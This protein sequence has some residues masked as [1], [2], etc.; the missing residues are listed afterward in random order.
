MLSGCFYPPQQKPLAAKSI[1]VTLDRPYDLA[2]DAVQAVVA[3]NGFRVI[4]ANPNDGTIEAQAIGKGFTLEDADC[5]KLRG[6][7]AKIDAEP[8]F[9]AS[10]VYD[11]RVEAKEPQL[12]T[13][14]I[15]AT[16][17]APLHVPLHPVTDIE[18]VSRGRQEARLLGEI[19][20][21]APK[22]RR[23]IEHAAPDILKNPS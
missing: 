4:T 23:A 3:N 7:G 2:W 5:G 12:S 9:D 11:L 13:V 10:A 8:D 21:E 6:A 16:F 17:T 18:C 1:A 20:A 15:A 22:H 14:T 19:K